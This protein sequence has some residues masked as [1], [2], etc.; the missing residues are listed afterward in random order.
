MVMAAKRYRSGE[1]RLFHRDTGYREGRRIR[2]SRDRRAVAKGTAWGR[3]VEAG[4]WAGAEFAFLSRLWSDGLPVPYPVQ[5]YGTEILM[6]LITDTDGVPAP[7][8]VQTR[9]DRPTLEAYWEQLDRRPCAGWPGWGWPTATCPRST[10]WPPASGI[11]II[12]LP[13]AVDIVSNPQGMD[14]LARDCRNVATWFAEPRSGRRRRRPAGRPGGVRL[15]AALPHHSCSGSSVLLDLHLEQERGTRAAV[16][17]RWSR[18]GSAGCGS[19]PRPPPRARRPATP[20]RPYPPAT[21]SKS[22]PGVSATPS[23]SSRAAHQATLSGCGPRTAPMS[24][25]R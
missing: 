7:R 21:R 17:V 19:G 12:D 4:T 24:A 25:Y 11:V 1:H 3:Q 6:E 10:C 20:V 2:K 23:D 18:P 14:F 9:P 15:V 22:V 13:Q 16:K 5:L 8:L